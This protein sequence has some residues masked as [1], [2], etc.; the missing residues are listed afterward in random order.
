M[1]LHLL[2]PLNFVRLALKKNRV[3]VL[4]GILN[5]APSAIQHRFVTA[6]P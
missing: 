5:K 1:C 2:M 6:T 4:E 3:H